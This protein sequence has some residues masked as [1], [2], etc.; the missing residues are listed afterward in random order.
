MSFSKYLTK[1]E[2][3]S[4]S[5]DLDLL[6]N[7]C[8]LTEAYLQT[9]YSLHMLSDYTM[10]IC[11]FLGLIVVLL[12]ISL[13]IKEKSLWTFYGW[14]CFWQAIVD[15]LTLVIIGFVEAPFS[16]SHDLG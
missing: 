2:T 5:A 4:V 7:C 1:S 16:I 11:G 13:Y 10:T 6:C 9:T 12:F 8:N 3:I 15:S 14:L